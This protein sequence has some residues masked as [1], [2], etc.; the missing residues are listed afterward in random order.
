VVLKRAHDE[1]KNPAETPAT[2]DPESLNN[3]PDP[4]LALSRSSL[5]IAIL[6]FPSMIYSSCCYA[7]ISSPAASA[8]VSFG[9][10]EV[11]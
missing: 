1:F 6:T 11:S 9:Y 10:F 5:T 8:V 3:H 7:V 4:S 2:N